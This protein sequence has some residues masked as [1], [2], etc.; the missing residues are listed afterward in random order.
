[1]PSRRDQIALTPAEQR[2]YLESSHTIILTTIDRRG[3]PH[4]VAMWYAVDPAD[5]AVVMTTFRKSQKVK[6]IE[7]DPRCALLIE[8]GREYAKLKGLLIRGRATIED[9]KEHVLDVLERISQKYHGTSGQGVRQAMAGQAA[10]RVVLRVV[11]ERISS[12]DH[13]KLAPGVY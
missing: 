8:S 11:P 2:E 4:S 13:S 10:K 12:W 9:G 3:Y 6:N 1:M 5:G 7:R